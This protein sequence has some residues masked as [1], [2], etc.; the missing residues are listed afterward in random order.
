MKQSK[1]KACSLLAG[2]A[3]VL[4]VGAAS[5]Q[6]EATGIEEGGRKVVERGVV[7]LSMPVRGPETRA[8]I[9]GTTL[10]WQAG[11]QLVMASNGQINGT[12]SCVSTT[13]DGQGTFT[14][15]VSQFTPESVN[16]F[17]VGNQSVSGGA[18]ASL[19]FSSQDGKA[20]TLANKFTFLKL[21][22]IQLTE[23]DP[24][25]DPYHYEI[26]GGSALHMEQITGIKYINLT[27]K[28]LP[29]SPMMDGEEEVLGVRPTK[30]RF[31]GLRNRMKLDLTTGTYTVDFDVDRTPVIVSPKA[32]DYAD[33]YVMAVLPQ[34]A[35]GVEMTV[36]FTGSSTSQKTWSGINWNVKADASG[37]YIT[38]WSLQSLTQIGYSYKNSYGAGV[39]GESESMSD[40]LTGKNGYGE[41][42]AD[43]YKSD[44]RTGKGGYRG[45]DVY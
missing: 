9:E 8:S 42:N 18:V 27:F 19:D 7:S 34:K 43:G 13:T 5:C 41:G 24:T 45:G 39:V 20:S 12:L 29:D 16:L 11:D 32:V 44:D 2:S 14:G 36:N 23:V 30:V 37:E 38:N 21:L 15:E 1:L 25:G 22:D 26:S 35:E 33:T 6:K 28:D 40:G 17:F 3:L 4:L 10:K 31:D